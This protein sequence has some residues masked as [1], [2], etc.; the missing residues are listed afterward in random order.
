MID[1]DVVVGPSAAALPWDTGADNV[2]EHYFKGLLSES[3]WRRAAPVDVARYSSAVI[4]TVLFLSGLS[5]RDGLRTIRLYCR[6]VYVGPL[7]LDA[8]AAPLASCVFGIVN[9]S[10]LPLTI[11]RQHLTAS[12]REYDVLV[13]SLLRTFAKTLRILVEGERDVG[14]KYCV[15]HRQALLKLALNR[16]KECEEFLPFIP[17]RTLSGEWKT[18]HGVANANKGKILYILPENA[19]DVSEIPDDRARNTLSFSDDLELKACSVLQS[20]YSSRHVSWEQLKQIHSGDRVNYLTRIAKAMLDESNA[21]PFRTAYSGLPSVNPGSTGLTQPSRAE[22]IK[23][24]R[25]DPS[26]LEPVQKVNID[27]ARLLSEVKHEGA[28]ADS[29]QTRR[30]IHY[31]GF[32]AVLRLNASHEIVRKMFELKRS[33]KADDASLAKIIFRLLLRSAIHA[34]VRDWYIYYEDHDIAAQ[35]MVDSCEYM[36]LLYSE[37]ISLN[38]KRSGV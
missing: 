30:L 22:V 37:R 36:L 7:S 9:S 6:R 25:K 35:V 8:T 27:L 24:S 21:E 17:F 38:A 33:G 1:T 12:N 34:A 19:P 14:P 2:H 16:P 15:E 3:D 28:A 29:G 18:A 23:A 10:T 31:R 32:E 26:W 5:L 11:D 20:R 4:N 13:S